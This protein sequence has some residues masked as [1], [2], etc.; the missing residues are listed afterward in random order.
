VAVFT[1]KVLL[2]SRPATVSSRTHRKHGSCGGCRLA[3]IKAEDSGAI[4]FG[5]I[6]ESGNALEAIRE[7]PSR[8]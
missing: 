4:R 2:R 7:F 8:L 5:V 6:R 3:L 1:E